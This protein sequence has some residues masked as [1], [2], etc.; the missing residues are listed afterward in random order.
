MNE[1][2]RLTPITL[3]R[4]EPVTKFVIDFLLSKSFFLCF[5]CK[6]LTSVYRR[7]IRIFHRINQ[8]AIICKAFHTM[9]KYRPCICMV[10]PRKQLRNCFTR[11][12]LHAMSTLINLRINFLFRIEFYMKE[13]PITILIL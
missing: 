13:S 12:P 2:N 1:R 8:E 10:F 6:N 7:K 11:I 4:E 9:L 3:T 5:F